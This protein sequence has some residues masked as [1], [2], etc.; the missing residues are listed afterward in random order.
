MEPQDNPVCSRADLVRIATQEMIDRGL[1]PAF[2]AA[3]VR[4][5]DTL[6][7]ADAE[8]DPQILDLSA[9]PWCSIDNDDSLDLDQLS[10]CEALAGGAVKVRVAVAD[11]DALVHPGSA[12]D[13]HAQFNTTS[14]YTS[15]KVFPMLPE[16]LSTDLTSL[17]PGQQRLALVTEMLIAEDAEILQSSVYRA[18]VRNQ[19]KLAYDA[20]AAWIE[21]QGPL[22]PAA[23]AVPGM[24]EQLRVQDAVAQRLR[25]R[26]QAQGSLEFQSF[27]PR[28]LFDGD[29]VVDIRQQVQNRARQLIEE[30]M[31]AT[32]SC[33]ARFLAGSGRPSLR[34]VVRSPER[35]LRIVEV[36]RKYGEALP[37]APDAQAL[38]AFLARRRAAD[39]LRFADLSLVIIKLMGSGEYVL[40]QPGAPALG[41]FGLAVRDYT[42]STAPNRRYPDLITSRLVKAILSAAPP[43]YNARE[44]ETLAEH[45]TQQENAAQKV[46]RRV[47]KSEAAL[48]LQTHLG[49]SFDAIVTGHSVTDSWVRIFAPPAEG[50]LVNAAPDTEVGQQLRVKLVATDVER[51]FI[52]FAAVD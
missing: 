32:N 10:C 27:Q 39:P 16:R 8:A 24:D 52:D 7:S 19:A 4:Q 30:L 11:V 18:R 21:G 12:I 34:R 14:V 9:L 51:G 40:E 6:T 29:R 20:V 5:V 44:L 33:T 2:P 13:A 25:E 23:A 41:H 49:Q 48:V 45:C 50:K 28:A 1:Q 42:H 36:A 46:E 37:K 35:W 17:N 22:P 38:E 43:P 15:A 26:R 31:I 3:V 47:R